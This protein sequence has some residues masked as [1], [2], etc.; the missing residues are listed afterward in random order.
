MGKRQAYRGDPESKLFYLVDQLVGGI[1]TDFSDDTS[2]DNEFKSII[3]FNMDRRGSL[4]KRMGFGKLNALSEIFNMFDNIP[5]TKVVTPEDP[6]PE[7]TN[8]NIV[9]MKLLRNDNNCFRNLSAFTGEKAY[10]EYQKVYGLQNNTFELL[11]VTSSNVTGKSTAWW[12]KCTLPPLRYIVTTP[13]IGMP[14]YGEE[15]I[16][17]IDD[18]IE[19]A[20]EIYELPVKF[21]WDRTMCNID[22][23]E[24]FDKIYLTQN[25]KGLVCFDRATN[26]FSYS[27]T[28]IEGVSNSAYKPSPMEVRKIGFNVM[29]D[30]PLH[31]IDY[32]GISTDSIQGVYLTSNGNI[33]LNTIPS[34]GK[35]QLN[36]LYTGAYSG[37]DV[38]FKEGETSLSATLTAN[39]ALTKTGIKVF[40]VV[41][42][43]TPTSEVE[44]KI[45]KTSSSIDP[46]Y[47]Y[48][49]VGPIDPETKPIQN[50]NIGE[51]RMCEMYNRA[52]Y[53][54]DD[55]IWFSEIN[56][57]SYVPNYN[58]VSLPIEPTD[59][60]TKIVFF[61][62]VY[63]IFTK[64]RIYKMI[65]SFGASDFQVMPVNMSIGCHA[66]NTVVPIEN[67]LYFASPR[68][69]YALKSSE[70]REGIENLKELD[71]KIKKLTADV[72]M[73]LGEKSDPSIRYNGIPEKA[74][75]VRYKDK[76]MIFLN[77]SREQGEIALQ[78]I[79]VLVYQYELKA[80]SEIK[81]PVKPTFLFMVDGA[82]ETFCTVPEK[83]VYDTENTLMEFDFAEQ[84]ENGK[85]L[86]K[87]ENGNDATISGN[88]IH[89][90]G[91][92]LLLKGSGTYIKTANIGTNTDLTGGFDIR[93][94]CALSGATG[95]DIYFFKQT[96]P[97]GTADAQSFSIVSDVSK[98]YKVELICNTVPNVSTKI[99]KVN[100][101]VRLHRTSTGV[102]PAEDGNY[103]LLDSYGNYLIPDTE[104]S[105]SFGNSLYKDI[106]TGSFSCTHDSSGNY[107]RDWTLNLFTT[108]STTDYIWENGGAV[109]ISH[110]KSPSWGSDIGIRLEGTASV[111]DGVGTIKIRPVFIM[112]SLTTLTLGSRTCEI[113]ID[114]KTYTSTI[115][116]VSGSGY[117]EFV[118]G[119]VTHTYNY[120][121]ATEPTISIS[122]KHN[123]NV[124][125]G[126]TSTVKYTSWDIPAFN[127]KLPYSKLESYLNTTLVDLTKVQSVSLNQLLANSYRQ[128]RLYV[129]GNSQFTLAY[130][131][132][133]T[134]GIQYATITSDDD[135]PISGEHDWSI[136]H[137]V[138]GGELVVTVIQDTREFG[139]ASLSLKC[140]VNG[141]R[142]DC[143]ILNNVNGSVKSYYMRNRT[144]GNYIFDY[145]FSDASASKTVTDTSGN[146]NNGTIYGDTEYLR[147]NGIKF[148]GKSAHLIL[149][150]ILS[151]VRFSNGFTIEFESKFDSIGGVCRLIDLAAGYN[152]DENANN[153]CSI[154]VG[155]TSNSMFLQSTS[156]N[157]KELYLQGDYA[158]LTEKHKYKF[159]VKDTGDGYKVTLYRDG[160][161]WDA[162][163]YNYGCITNTDRRSNFIGKS[164]DVNGEYFSGILYNFKLTIAASSNPNPVYVG[165]IYEYETTY[166][167]FGRPMEIGFETKGI[168]LQYPMHIKKLKNLHIKGLGGFNYSEFFLEVYSDG[169]LLND[170]KSYNCYVDENTGQV[171]YDYTENKQLTFNEM[172]SLLGNMRLGKTKLGESTYET[173][174]ILL[175]GTGKGKN[176]TIKMYG[177]SDDFLSIE[178]IGF[179]YKLGKVKEK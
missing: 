125:W 81:F 56:N 143:K 131:S 24:F 148:D 13:S 121:G 40:D 110:K 139:S 34:G 15:T 3:N 147:E 95:E 156:A 71:T 135:K 39:D 120:N 166:D 101:T 108:Y 21:N 31:W 14:G 19:L 116:A 103:S 55:T 2:P 118:G 164:N 176:F 141:N 60:I 146:G 89:N 43:T 5:D 122:A 57:F 32:K 173:R 48:Y 10:Q 67:E 177:E 9:Y 11:I 145:D 64:Q 69:V 119:Y 75:A 59:K 102:L 117:K 51:C 129:S 169:H 113:T 33:P 7:K 91:V 47:D 138:I 88:I 52:V 26:T 157:A 111:K 137:R 18:T 38:E 28:G 17:G 42:T 124:N 105:V 132:E 167:D 133:Y 16:V 46:Y 98:G 85:Y 130:D 115:P 27:G 172:V 74:Q 84:P 96:S 78:D 163:K 65:N 63:I 90:P 159:E 25:D 49:Q 161:L 153:K 36:I 106:A 150:A 126:K 76:Y 104:F 149:P 128:M 22:T 99:T 20:C 66:P 140:L 100:Y 87:S 179:T 160:T 168:N 12:Y 134:D 61:K 127:V 165:A 29:G 77:A 136:L 45:S 1:N 41:F 155:L 107:A 112:G 58:Y 82:I 93:T 109:T 54:K 37:F 94:K 6:N 30:D 178:S 72:T 70:F 44:I 162:T 80:F 154:N 35:F 97:S 79:D 86:D 158:D 23:I 73:Y 83:E 114:G 174:K 68:G 53:Y 8:D 171:V 151:D 170:P 92:E 142:S 175:P 152:T 62:N 123:I 50:V 144:T 4:Y